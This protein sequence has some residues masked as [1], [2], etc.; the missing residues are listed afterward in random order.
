MENI[1][2]YEEICEAFAAC[3]FKPRAG[4]IAAASQVLQGFL[5][6]G[7]KISVLNAPTGTGKS[8]LGAVI[9]EVLERKRG[10]DGLSSF[11]LMGQNVLAQ[12]YLHTFVEKENVSTSQF[13]FLKGANN[14]NCSA[15]SVDGEEISA[16]SCA[17]KVLQ[18]NG[19]DDIVDE[20]CK[21]CEYIQNK[22]RKNE[23]R[24]LI[25]NYSYYFIDRLYMKNYPGS[26]SPRTIAI[27][28]EAQTVNDLFV[29]HNAIYFS[30]KRLK[31]YADELAAHL[32]IGNTDVSKNLKRISTDLKAGLITDKNYLMYLKLL[33]NVY[34]EA[35]T[36]AEKEAKASIRSISKYNS[37]IKLHKK[38]FGLG[39]KIDDL[40]KY[41]YDHIFEYKKENQEVNVKAVFCGSMFNELINSDF[42]L[43]MS[44]TIT[45]E[46]LIETLDLNPNDIKFVQLE[47]TFPKESKKVVFLS[48]M[49]LNYTS[50]KE[51]KTIKSLQSKVESIVKHHIAKKESG[52]VLTPSFELTRQICDKLNDTS[53]YDVFEHKQGEKLIDVLAKFKAYHGP[54]V[55]VSP[56]L[57][58]GI[59][60]DDEL[61]RFQVFVKAPY[62]SLGD[63]RMKHILDKHPQIYEFITLL[64]V[65]QGC[66]RSTRSADDFSV[67]YMLD[68]NLQRLWKSSQN[69]WKNEF[70]VTYKMMLCD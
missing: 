46:Y 44:A 20:H 35:A 57:F 48:P 33:H 70:D 2:F 17:L 8:I 13:L 55:L 49:Q 68:N 36:S 10:K 64:K 62:P 19:M 24:N 38:Y 16:E 27:F 11:M 54:S 1:R 18:E 42:I 34:K 51:E 21:N 3:G 12:Q 66:G 25:T 50:L 22:K 15:L 5:D 14:F 32:K 29:E 52:I 23:C 40:L 60:L 7:K 56:S 45:K 39:C 69:I 67:T 59:S 30:E 6:E 37:L 41:N 43:F 9:A 47:P 58:E 65:I 63:K 28:D 61:S 31:Q 26:M 4:Q 53:I